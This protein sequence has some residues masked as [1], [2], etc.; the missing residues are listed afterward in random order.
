[1]KPYKSKFAVEAKVTKKSFLKEKNASSFITEAIS[2]LEKIDITDPIE[3]N[4]DLFYIVLDLGV[5]AEA[6]ESRANS[7]AA[8]MA[9]SALRSLMEEFENTIEI[10]KKAARMVDGISDDIEI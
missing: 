3:I 4:E 6:Q 1:M 8:D 7:K 5:I 2:R 10:V 9:Q